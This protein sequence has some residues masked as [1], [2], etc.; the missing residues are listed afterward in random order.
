MKSTMDK[1]NPDLKQGDRICGYR[2]ERIEP[3]KEIAATFYEL[4][5]AATGAK[6]VPKPV[7]SWRSSHRHSG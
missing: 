2:I 3:L 5:H 1:F 6:H 4:E 7:N